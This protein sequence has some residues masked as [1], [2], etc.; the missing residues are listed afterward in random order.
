MMYNKKNINLTAASLVK[1]SL[2]PISHK[3]IQ[4]WFSGQISQLAGQIFCPDVSA[5]HFQKLFRALKHD[6]YV[7]N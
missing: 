7:P 3:W 6:Y 1:G 5:G 4:C 2:Y